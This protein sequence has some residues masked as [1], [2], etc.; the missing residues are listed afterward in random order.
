MEVLPNDVDEMSPLEK[1]SLDDNIGLIVYQQDL[2]THV[3]LNFIS[4][5][6]FFFVTTKMTTFLALPVEIMV[7]SII[8]AK[9]TLKIITL[10]SVTIL[11]KPK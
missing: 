5:I 6:D 4:N 7:C 10:R 1:V 9:I 2:L 11:W 8:M 3:F